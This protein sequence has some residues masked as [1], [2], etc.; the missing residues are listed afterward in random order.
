MAVI[1]DTML[2]M[3]EDPNGTAHTWVYNVPDD[4]AQKIADEHREMLEQ[5]IIQ[6]LTIKTAVLVNNN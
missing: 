6:N 3:H 5:G 1:Y 4:K 2:I